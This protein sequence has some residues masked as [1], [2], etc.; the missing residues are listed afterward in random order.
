MISIF[1]FSYNPETKEAAYA[2]NISLPE[3]LNILQ[4]LVIADAVNK[5]RELDKQAKDVKIEEKK[6]DATS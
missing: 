4:N 6:E 2:G 1:T 3:A 5:A